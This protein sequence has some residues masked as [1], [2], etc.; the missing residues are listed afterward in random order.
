[1]P[2]KLRRF[3]LFTKT[4]LERSESLLFNYTVYSAS[5]KLVL[6]RSESLLFN[7]TVYSASL[8]LIWKEVKVCFSAA[9]FT[10]RH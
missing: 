1:M 3:E 5:L 4:H 2:H 10:V 6:E 7:Y 8:N 9:R